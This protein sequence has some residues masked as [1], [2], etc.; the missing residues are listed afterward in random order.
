MY[1][2]Y[3]KYKAA[4][5]EQNKDAAER[6]CRQFIWEIARCVFLI[7]PQSV[8]RTIVVFRHAVGEEL[9]VYPLMEEHLGQKGKELA[10]HDRAEHIDVKKH[11]ESLDK[12]ISEGKVGT[13]EFD[14]KMRET[15]E[16]LKHHNDDE[17]RDDLP[18]LEPKIGGEGSKSAAKHFKRTKVFA[19][20]R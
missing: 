17:E 18:M 7:T 14:E 16:H 1:E 6:W 11:L 3:D 2:Y 9:I 19:P 12:Y 10:D 8:Y 5:G 15:Y 20:T 13:K 4:I